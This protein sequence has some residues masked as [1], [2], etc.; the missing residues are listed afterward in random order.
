MS[1]QSS[2]LKK[3]FLMVPYWPWTDWNPENWKA[4]ENLL[5]TRAEPLY[6]LVY[7]VVLINLIDITIVLVGL[8]N[9]SNHSSNI[10]SAKTMHH[11]GR[12]DNGTWVRTEPELCVRVIFTQDTNGSMRRKS[13]TLQRVLEHLFGLDHR[14]CGLQSRVWVGASAVQPKRG[15]SERESGWWTSERMLMEFLLEESDI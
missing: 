3:I 13:C 6:P 7:I 5:S 9:K 11:I 4:C 10:E 2:D 15:A 14:K 8:I 12:F 1:K